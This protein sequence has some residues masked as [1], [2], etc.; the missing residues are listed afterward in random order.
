MAKL[1]E[2]YLRNMIKQV[3]KENYD[4]YADE[5]KSQFQD[6]V[7][8]IGDEE[9]TKITDATD[10]VMDLQD[11]VKMLIDD[12][13]GASSVQVPV[14]QLQEIEEIAYKIYDHLTESG[15]AAS[16][17]GRSMRRAARKTGMPHQYSAGPHFGGAIDESR[18]SK[19]TPKRK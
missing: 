7:A 19:A 5:A 14:S 3:M 4:D 6:E 13:E 2:S 1:T 11:I 16:I 18:K 10:A 15:L 12:A 8:E 17:K 9:E